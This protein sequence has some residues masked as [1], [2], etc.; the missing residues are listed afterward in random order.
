M[1][2][3]NSF[4]SINLSQFF[5]SV[6]FDQD[7]D[8]IWIRI[9]FSRT[10]YTSRE[11]GD[12]GYFKIKGMANTWSA[13]CRLQ[14]DEIEKVQWRSEE[15]FLLRN[16][17]LRPSDN[18]FYMFHVPLANRVASSHFLRDRKLEKKMLWKRVFVNSENFTWKLH[19]SA[20]ICFLRSHHIRSM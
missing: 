14:M 5:D 15:W 18:V 2:D 6:N 16:L 12:Y 3:L 17:K 9:S 8:M 20:S 10:F 11:Y 13:M 7:Q 19:R 1:T 4:Q